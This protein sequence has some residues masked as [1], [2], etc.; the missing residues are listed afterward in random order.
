MWRGLVSHMPGLGSTVTALLQG[1]LLK[2]WAPALLAM[3]PLMGW[4]FQLSLSMNCNGRVL[5]TCQFCREGVPSSDGRLRC[6]PCCRS[7][8]GCS[9]CPCS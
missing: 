8:T 4:L 5:H 3:L 6:W 2:R 1:A 9:S 7:W